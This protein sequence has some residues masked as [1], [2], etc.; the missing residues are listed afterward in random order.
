M[1]DFR[2]D[3]LADMRSQ[4]AKLR[5]AAERAM[6]QVGDDDF[7]KL[8][9]GESNS[10]AIIVKHVS[11]N[12]RSRCTNFLTSDGE[13]ADRDRDDEFVLHPHETRIHL[14]NEWAAAWD[15]LAATVAALT[16]DD[17]QRTIYIR[18]EPHTVVQA[19]NRHLGHLAY[20]VGQIVLLAKHWV[21]TN[22]ETLTIA[23]GQSKAFTPAVLRDR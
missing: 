1:V 19:L 4:F 18:A 12:L 16:P 5:S 6:A 14:L 21:G 22:W 10:I 13:K 9:D 15:L 11:G 3:Y 20:H 7:A 2:H 23:R 17:L 8:L